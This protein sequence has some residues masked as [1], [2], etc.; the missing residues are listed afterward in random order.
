[1]PSTWQ[2]PMWSSLFGLV[3]SYAAWSCHPVRIAAHLFKPGF[4]EEV[5]QV[6]STVNGKIDPLCLRAKGLLFTRT[7]NC[8]DVP[9]S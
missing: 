6:L 1:M 2:G 8:L 5:E 7:Q 9:R 3:V 4:P